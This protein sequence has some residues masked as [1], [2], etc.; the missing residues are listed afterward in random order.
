[1]LGIFFMLCYGEFMY[2][3][4]AGGVRKRMRRNLS[5]L[6]IAVVGIIVI[7]SIL[8]KVLRGHTV[9]HPNII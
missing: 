1:M 5:Y 8:K 2:L 3:L 7:G 6:Y 9:I 4:K